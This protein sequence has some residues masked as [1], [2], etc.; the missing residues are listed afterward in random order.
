[1]NLNKGCIE[2][3]VCFAIPYRIDWWTLTRVVLKYGS[4]R[5]LSANEIEMNLNKGCIEMK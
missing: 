1:M 2:I 5:L 3:G 4:E